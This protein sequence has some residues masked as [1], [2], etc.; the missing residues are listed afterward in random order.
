[1]SPNTA[2]ILF[3]LS[4]ASIALLLLA[5]GGIVNTIAAI[6]VAAGAV[7]GWWAVEKTMLAQALDQ[8]ATFLEG[9]RRAGEASP[10]LDQAHQASPAQEPRDRQG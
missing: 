8:A 2:R 4:T 10:Q 5:A 6:L 3:F 1:M 7:P 9:L